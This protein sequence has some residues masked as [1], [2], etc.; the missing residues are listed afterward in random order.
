[1]HHTLYKPAR[2]LCTVHTFCMCFCGFFLTYD[3]FVYFVKSVDRV[4]NANKVDMTY[5]CI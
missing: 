4:M 1:M 3:R 5:W 2:L